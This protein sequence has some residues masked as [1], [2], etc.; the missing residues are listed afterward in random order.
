MKRILHHINKVKERPHHVR[1]RIA[2]TAAFSGTAVIALAWL[3]FMLGSGTFAIQGSSFADSQQASTG[4]SVSASQGLAGAAAAPVGR[5]DTPARIE[6][7]DAR[8][9]ATSTR[10][11]EATIL[12]F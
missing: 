10:S 7:I 1:R 12:P 5:A 11:A 4:T 6:I 2:M 8:T 3:A 9:A